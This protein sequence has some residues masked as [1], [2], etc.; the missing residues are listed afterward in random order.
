MSITYVCPIQYDKH[1]RT[2][3][4]FVTELRQQDNTWFAEITSYVYTNGMTDGGCDLLC[5]EFP[6]INFDA[7][8]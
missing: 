2:A 4:H 6:T 1:L 3:K 5:V 7:L 8:K